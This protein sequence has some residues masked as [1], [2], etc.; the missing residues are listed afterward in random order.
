MSEDDVSN[1]LK[2]LEDE[3]GVKLPREVKENTPRRVISSLKE[4][5]SGYQEDAKYILEK[6]FEQDV[7]GM[8]TCG[9][10]TFTSICEHHLLPFEGYAVIAYIPHNGEVVGASKLPRLV[11]CFARR[12]QL[13]E[14]MTA[15]IAD[16]IENYVSPDV[17]VLTIATH[18]CIRCRG[19][20]STAYLTCVELRGEFL[21]KPEVREE[22]Y[23]L[24]SLSTKK[25]SN[26]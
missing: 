24:V 7:K 15:Q 23:S 11:N 12:L 21:S 2:H 20:S 19:I 5:L 14:R 9:P 3:L 18:G 8:L 25:N 6:K 16:A 10:I 1:L 4:M 17:A 13:Q 26:L 22:F